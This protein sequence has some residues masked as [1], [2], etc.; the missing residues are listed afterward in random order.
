MAYGAFYG[1]LTTHHI[2][3]RRHELHNPAGE[4]GYLTLEGVPIA[5]PDGFV[6]DYA[7]IP[8]WLQWLIPRDGPHS[9]AAVI[10]DWLY[11][12][13]RVGGFRIDRGEADELFVECLQALGGRSSRLL[14]LYAGVRVGGWW[15]WARY[16]RWEREPEQW[17]V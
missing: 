3:G 2:D 8:F 10:H 17:G 15:P 13:G 16:R 14:A 6:T 1:E 9:P 4:W 12:S 7:S 11:R 5:P